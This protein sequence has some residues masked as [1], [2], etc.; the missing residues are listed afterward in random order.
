MCGDGIGDAK[1]IWAGHQEHLPYYP[2]PGKNTPI[3]PRIPL[4]ASNSSYSHLFYIYLLEHI[5]LD[6]EGNML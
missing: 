2:N 5:S 4:L 3:V 6:I 1:V